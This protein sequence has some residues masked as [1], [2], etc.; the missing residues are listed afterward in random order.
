MVLKSFDQG[1]ALFI[2]VEAP[3]FDLLK[4]KIL[5]KN[6]SS[7]DWRYPKFSLFLFWLAHTKPNLKTCAAQHQASSVWRNIK[8]L[9]L[10]RYIKLLPLCRNIKPLLPCGDL[11]TNLGS[12]LP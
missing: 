8:L 4:I 6:T 9:L 12:V 7:E 3:P 2:L 11:S 5:F 10:W 1:F